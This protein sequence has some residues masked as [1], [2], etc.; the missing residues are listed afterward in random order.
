MD[1]WM[2]SSTMLESAT[3]AIYWIPT[4]QFSEMLWKQITLDPLLSL[5]V[6][7]EC[8]LHFLMPYLSSI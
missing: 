1:K 8:G 5:K 3:V 4:F 7:E 6:S 2:S